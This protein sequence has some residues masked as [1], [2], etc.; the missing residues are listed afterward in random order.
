MHLFLLL[1]PDH[2]LQGCHFLE[3]VEMSGNFTVG[4]SGN[5]PNVRETESY[6]LLTVRSGLHHALVD[7]GRAFVACF[8]G[9]AVSQ[10]VGNIFV[11]YP[12]TF[13]V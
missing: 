8:D 13:A 11:D 4:R 12:L 10:V 5:K 1:L 9:F 6:L 3:N 7:C 2:S